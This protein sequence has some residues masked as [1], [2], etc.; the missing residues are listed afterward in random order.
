M[1]FGEDINGDGS[2]VF[3]FEDLWDLAKEYIKR[4]NLGTSHTPM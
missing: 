3:K 2:M 1:D 4:H